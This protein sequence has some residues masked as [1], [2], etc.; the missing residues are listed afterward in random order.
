MN[1]VNLKPA[2]TSGELQRI[3]FCFSFYKAECYCNFQEKTS[4][5][6]QSVRLSPPRGKPQLLT[7]GISS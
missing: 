3:T 6:Y 4:S 1:L 5:M 7:H 2:A